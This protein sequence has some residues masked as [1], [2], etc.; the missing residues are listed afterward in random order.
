LYI[1]KIKKPKVTKKNLKA[2]A[3]KGSLL[4]VIGFVVTKA[5]DHKIIK[6]NGKILIIFAL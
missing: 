4:S 3:E 6:K 5:D 1:I 2:S